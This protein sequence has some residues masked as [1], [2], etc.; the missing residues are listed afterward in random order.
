[1]LVRNPSQEHDTY[2][3]GGIAAQYGR[4]GY[5]DDGNLYHYLQDKFCD[6]FHKVFAVDGISLFHT[7]KHTHIHTHNCNFLCFHSLLN[8]KHICY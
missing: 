5:E 1:M 4:K 8:N 2:D 6:A 3:G 7:H